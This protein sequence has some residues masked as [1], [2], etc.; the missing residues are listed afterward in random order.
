MQFRSVPMDIL[1]DLSYLERCGGGG[2]LPL[3]TFRR[4][5][6]KWKR[7][8]LPQSVQMSPSIISN[9]LNANYTL[10]ESQ[11]TI[12]QVVR[13]QNKKKNKKY[14]CY[15]VFTADAPEDCIEIKILSRCA[16]QNL[17]HGAGTCDWRSPA[18]S[19]RRCSY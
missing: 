8:P 14:N 2:V 16:H 17:I 18:I 6:L 10:S 15:L 3:T 13:F 4:P 1:Y 11:C 12:W 9:L 19:D 5:P 7:E